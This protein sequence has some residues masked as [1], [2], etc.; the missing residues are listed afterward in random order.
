MEAILLC[1]FSDFL[2]D[3]E[4]QFH[5][6]WYDISLHPIEN[7]KCK[8][9]R[10]KGPLVVGVIQQSG[11]NNSGETNAACNLLSQLYKLPCNMPRDQA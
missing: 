11:K 7:G 1:F 8:K 4:C 6:F 9:I 3:S 5:D 10:C 2:N